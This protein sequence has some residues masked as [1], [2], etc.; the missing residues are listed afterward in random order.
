M[1][2]NQKLFRV[3]RL[4]DNTISK[5]LESQLI[6]KLKKLAPNFDGILVSD[7]VYG[8]ITEKIREVLN[9]L[10]QKL[11]IKLFGDLQCSTQVGNI[12]KFQNFDLL[13]PTEKE[14]RIALGN[15]D[16]GVEWIANKLMKQ[17][18]TKDLLSKWVLRVLL[19]FNRKR[20]TY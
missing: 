17:T 16:D 3:S 7:F 20:W 13:T 4:N 8:V 1:V 12:S 5:K 18:Q 10:K 9:E 2:E 15:R 14:A 6:D 11:N 19:L